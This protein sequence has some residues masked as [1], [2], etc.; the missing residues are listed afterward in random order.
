MLY[1]NYF[2]DEHYNSFHGITTVTWLLSS[3][4]HIVQSKI[5]LSC[6]RK[7]IYEIYVF[8]QLKPYRYLMNLPVDQT[9]TGAKYEFCYVFYGESPILV[10]NIFGSL[11]F[12]PYS[13]NN[14][15][16]QIILTKST[17]NKLSNAYFKQPVQ[18]SD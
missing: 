13:M 8:V 5:E 6:P 10:T 17:P 16:T 11:L 18:H 3:L 4:C 14:T 12:Q 9:N 2:Y 1:S 7:G 15:S